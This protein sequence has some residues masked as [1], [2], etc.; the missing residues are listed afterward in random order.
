MKYFYLFWMWHHFYTW[1][2]L[3]RR[4]WSY[5]HKFFSVKKIRLMWPAPNKNLGAES[6]L[7]FSGWQCFYSC[8]YSQWLGEISVSCVTPLGVDPWKLMP[9]FSGLR[10]PFPIAD[11]ALYLSA[12]INHSYVYN[13]KKKKIK[14]IKLRHNS[15]SNSSEEYLYSGRPQSPKLNEPKSNFEISFISNQCKI[16]VRDTDTIWV[17]LK[18]KFFSVPTLNK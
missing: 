12:V 9:V 5:I 13:Q 2:C 6:L 8:H 10:L 4:N 17:L 11:Y 1:T 18:S 3:A 15:K 7:N 14:L 16:F